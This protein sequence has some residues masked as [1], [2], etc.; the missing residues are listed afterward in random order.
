MRVALRSLLVVNRAAVLGAGIVVA[1]AAMLLGITTAW[2]EAGVRHPEL[3]F[4]SSVAGSFAGT[5]LLITVFM[6]AN[7]FAGVLRERRREF[8]LLRAVGATAAQI[9]GT[10]RTEVLLLLALVAP[11]GAVVGTFAAASVT[12]LL[13]ASDIVPAG[14]TLTASVVPLL[15]TLV[16]L[17][18]TGLLAAAMAARAAT[19]PSP[20]DAVRASTTDVPTLS[21]GRR[22]AAGVTALAGLGIAATPFFTPGLVGSAAG[23][24]SAIV[25]VVAAALAGPLLVQWAA[26]RGL[27]VARRGVGGAASVLAL[28]NARGASRRL[29]AAVVPLAL[30]VALGTVQTGTDAAV[31]RATADQ[32]VAG[33]PADLVVTSSGGVTADQLERIAAVPGVRATTTMRDRAGSVQVEQPDEDLG[34]LGGLEWEPTVVRGLSADTRSVDPDV[35]SGS[36]AALDAPGTVAVSN[37]LVAL[38]PTGLGDTVQLRS[39]DSP[40]TSARVVAAY[41]RGLAFGDVL[42]RDRSA[43][44]VD[45][46]LVDARPGDRAAVREALLALDLRVTTADGYAA[47]VLRSGDGERRLSLVLVIALLAFVAAAAGSTLLT[48]MRGRR[49][50]F[51]L[52]QRTGAT[53]AQLLRMAGVETAFTA[54]AAVVIGTVAVV[55]ALVG[56]GQGLAGAP[57]SGFDVGAWAGFSGAAVVVAVLGVLPGVARTVRGR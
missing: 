24:T 11:L 17:V 2:L 53:R 27:A 6:V 23:A 37:D 49:G 3:P 48:A 39:G 15:T 57:S 30:L 21:T 54:V 51:G 4:L 36:L 14:F 34:G 45:T 16:V 56:V 28:L 20:T 29:S 22:I 46:L 42:V 32:L 33:L 25:L 5:L 35:R 47:S 19:R 18:P 7:V 9:R 44:P 41:D 8:A 26:R 43:G 52:L 1:L 55:P 13:R 50:E 38:T 10:V 12:P 40:A 31:D